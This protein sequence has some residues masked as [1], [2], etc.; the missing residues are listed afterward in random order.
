MSWSHYRLLIPI[1]DPKA[2][3]WYE[4]EAIESSWSVRTLQRNINTQ[5]YYRIM[6]SQYKE[7]VIE[8]M[9][10]KTLE[11]QLDKLEHVK[12]P[13]ILEF[14]GLSASDKLLESELESSII[15]NLQKILVEN[16]AYSETRDADGYTV[17]GL[18]D[19]LLRFLK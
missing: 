7:P 9:K 4:K 8:E 5:Y 19:F 3:E 2:R 13:V 12:N 16:K 17:I 1:E 18:P 15:S 14:L 10:E 11:Y 6:A